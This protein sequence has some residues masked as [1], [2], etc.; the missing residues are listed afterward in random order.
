MAPD[1]WVFPFPVCVCPCFLHHCP[2]FCLR[3]SAEHEVVVFPVSEEMPSTL[4]LLSLVFA[5]LLLVLCHVK[6]IPFGVC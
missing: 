2:A 5:G 4:S 6:E 3:R 1:L